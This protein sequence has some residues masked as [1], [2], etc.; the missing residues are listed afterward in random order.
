MNTTTSLRIAG[1]VVVAI[2]LGLIRNFAFPGGITFSTHSTEKTTTSQPDTL[3]LEITVQ[4]AYQLYQD[5]V[6]FIDARTRKEFKKEYI[7][8]A[9]NIPADASFDEK[10]RLTSQVNPDDPYVV[11]CNNPE[12]PLSHQLYEFLQFANFTNTHIMYEGIDEWKTAGYP[13][14]S[15]GADD[16]E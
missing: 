9:I 2:F 16:S 6:Q 1:I 7:P 13:V 4:T 5:S 15:G 12:C 8:G 3:S 11:Y 10:N 14:V